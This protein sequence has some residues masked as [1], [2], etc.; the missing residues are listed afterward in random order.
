M[1]EDCGVC[2]DPGDHDAPEMYCE[3]IVKAR[4][5]HD[6]CECE[7]KIE[8]GS[9]YQRTTGRW[10]GRFDVFCTCLDCVNIRDAFRCGGNFFFGQLWDSLHEFRND[11]NFDCVAKIKTVS[12]KQR[13]MDWL[14][15]VRQIAV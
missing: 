6:C 13:Y 8:S 11:V 2:L 15:K 12:A 9:E 14:R 10:D 7:I 4:K 5:P 3:K 1:I